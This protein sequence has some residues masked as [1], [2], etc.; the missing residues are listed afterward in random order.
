MI[1]RLVDIQDG[2]IYV[3]GLDTSDI[4]PRKLRRMVLTLPQETLIFQGT[5]RENID[6]RRERSDQDI[7]TALEACQI[8]SVLKS[9]YGEN[10]LDQDLSSDGTDLSAGQRQLVCAARVVLEQPAVL[11]VDEGRH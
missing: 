5:L 8:S 11:L 4:E 9:K 2:K 3:A 6:P 7:W 1:S 10:A